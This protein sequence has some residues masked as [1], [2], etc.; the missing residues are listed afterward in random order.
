MNKKSSGEASS[1]SLS[2]SGTRSSNNAGAASS[3]KKPS[4]SDIMNLLVNIQQEQTSQKNDMNNL[5]S[6]VN[7][8]YY[9]DENSVNADLPNDIDDNNNAQTDNDTNV[10]PEE[11]AEPP[12]KR[13]KTSDTSNVTDAEV[14]R[15]SSSIF[16]SVAN[17]YKAKDAV[18]S[19]IDDDLADVVNVFFREGIS[20]E[21]YQDLMKSIS[22]PE[23]CTSLTRTR[24]NQLV[25]DLLQPQ[26]RSF[27]SVIL[28]HQETVIKAS[29]NIA[30]LLSKLNQSD[31]T[32][33]NQ[34]K[35]DI[36]SCM[37]IGLESLGLLAQYNKMT[38]LKRKEYQKFDL[39]PEYHHLF[40]P[41]VPFTDMLYGDNVCQKSREI[42]DMNRLGRQLNNRG[43]GG[44]GR[45][46]FSR[47]R[48]G[49]NRGR[50]GYSRGRG[51]R[52]GR[53]RGNSQL[54]MLSGSKQTG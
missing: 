30:K 32:D 9:Y 29:C 5:Q 2:Q 31:M 26:T 43:R 12:S 47:G 39:S 52:G 48:G 10:D 16:K 27:N 21:K 45:G 20:D 24:V 33:E 40:S 54:A 34:Y 17:D 1:P 13:Q 6:M 42:Q 11:V 49:F 37:D 14:S 41:S 53:G 19:K 51:Y 3:R 4:L 46:G 38:N 28:Q 8:V 7:E 35:L 23:N 36:Q 44:F 15:T 25:W 50:G 18:D 22:R